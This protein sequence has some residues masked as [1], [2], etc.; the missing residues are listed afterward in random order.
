MLTF[1]TR[2]FGDST[3]LNLHVVNIDWRHPSG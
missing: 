2:P 3:L 1:R